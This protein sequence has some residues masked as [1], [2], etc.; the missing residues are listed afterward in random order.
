MLEHAPATSP[1]NAANAPATGLPAASVRA[2]V[3]VVIGAVVVTAVALAA[4]L[5]VV[6]RAEWWRGYAAASIA[7][8]LAT[9]ASLVPMAIGLRRGGPALVQ[10]FMLSSGVR[11]AVALGI[12]ALAVGA[13][14]YPLVPT[15]ALVIPYYLVLLGVESAILSRGHKPPP[16]SATKH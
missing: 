6:N 12:A 3:L 10:M 1:L 15:L 13:G 7:A 5:A 9:G 8:F 14:K 4:V 2:Q 16:P 11:G